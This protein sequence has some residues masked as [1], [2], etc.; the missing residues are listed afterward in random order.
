DGKS[1]SVSNVL[2]LG[3][4]E[5]FELATPIE[6]AYGKRVLVTGISPEL[7][8]VF[9]G[10]YLRKGP[11][12]GN[13][14]A[15]LLGGNHAIIAATTPAGPPG[16]QPN[17]P[18]LV[19]ALDGGTHGSFGDGQYFVTAAVHGTPWVIVSTAPENKLFASVSGAHKWIPWAIF[20]LLALAS[21]FA[22][23]LFAR[24]LRNAGQLAD[25]ND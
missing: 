1:F 20:A 24:A 15:F 18:G 14:A 22:L 19:G 11:N 2:R 6:S 5:T 16:S 4:L 13:G 21:A 12:V 9:L 17:T 25:A 7:L 23:F 8:A 3:K 10:S